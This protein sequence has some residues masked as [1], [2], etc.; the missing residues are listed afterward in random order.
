MDRGIEKWKLDYNQNRFVENLQ[1]FYLDKRDI[2]KKEQ[3]IFNFISFFN[4][5]EISQNRNYIKEREKLF[6]SLK[7]NNFFAN[8]FINK[9]NKNIFS[10]KLIVYI[11]KTNGIKILDQSYLLNSHDLSQLTTLKKLNEFKIK[12][13]ELISVEVQDLQIYNFE[14]QK[15]YFEFYDIFNIE[16]IFIYK[17]NEIFIDFSEIEKIYKI[18]SYFFSQILKDYI[19]QKL[20]HDLAIGIGSTMVSSKFALDLFALKTT[21]SIQIFDEKCYQIMQKHTKLHEI[22]SIDLKTSN[23]LKENGITNLEQFINLKTRSVLKILGTKGTEIHNNVKL[24]DSSNW[25]QKAKKINN[26]QK[27]IILHLIPMQKCLSK[28]ISFKPTQNKQIILLYTKQ[29]LIDCIQNLKKRDILGKTIK[30]EC[31][32]KNKEIKNCTKQKT[33]NSHINDYKEAESV[34]KELIKQIPS[35]LKIKRINLIISNLIN[36]QGQK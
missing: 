20:G 2:Q 30:I 16:N 12:H 36:N 14:L 10:T 5:H 17:D 8:I 32:F 33:L 11:K 22:W 35:K 4:L 21:S 9:E 19:Y 23:Q 24:N 13:P 6:L 27:E 34:I 29:S 18:R 3:N 26:V 15:I 1:K 28:S 31:I 7:I 25:K